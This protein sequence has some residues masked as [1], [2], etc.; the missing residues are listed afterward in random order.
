[1]AQ[2]FYTHGTMNSGKSIEVL[3]V[4]HNYEEQNKRVILLTSGVDNRTKVG[5]VASRIGLRKDAHC[6]YP[7][8][9]I[10]EYINQLEEGV[11]DGS[12]LYAVVVDECQFLT[13]KQVRQL[14]QLV[15]ECEV[16]VLCFGLK[17]DF[18]N[19]LFEGSQALLTYADKIHE[20]KTVCKHCN[21]K[22]TMNM[23]LHD[24]VPVYEG[25]QVQIGGNES[26]AAVCRA[27]YY[28][29]PLPV[30]VK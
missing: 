27:C 21:R 12:P 5:E 9:D 11:T 18:Q 2:F 23:R 3:K 22:A 8:T 1:M 17:N 19:Q 29:P 30:K 4:V 6:I 13:T 10:F 7:D 24:G 14:A 26:Y 20:M 16:P 28:N 25:E 15:D